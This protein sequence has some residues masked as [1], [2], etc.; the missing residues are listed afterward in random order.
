MLF[1]RKRTELDRHLDAFLTDPSETL[2]IY[3]F[4]KLPD[5]IKILACLPKALLPV[6]RDTWTRH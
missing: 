6:L 1:S 5:S 4:W 2:L 3:F